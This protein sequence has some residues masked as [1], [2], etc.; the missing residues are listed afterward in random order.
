MNIREIKRHIRLLNRLKLDTKVKSKARREINK[1]IRNLK[2]KL[3]C[4]ISPEKAEI[5]AKI[6]AIYL[7][8]NNLNKFTME[9]LQYH[10]NKLKEKGK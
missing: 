2:K 1:K 3:V 7:H 5:I 9:Q 4:K 8:H 6:N 10:L